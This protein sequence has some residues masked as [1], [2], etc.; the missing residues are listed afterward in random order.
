MWQ[1][2]HPGNP[3]KGGY[4]FSYPTGEKIFEKLADAAAALADFRQGNKIPNPGFNE[5]MAEID[6]YN[7]QRLGNHKNY[8]MNTYADTYQSNQTRKKA[9]ACSGCGA[10]L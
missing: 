1:I 9:A 6:A 10:V 3:I 7:C 2:K 5:C 4:R 8:C